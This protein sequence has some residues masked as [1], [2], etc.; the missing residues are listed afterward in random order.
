MR[1]HTWQLLGAVAAISTLVVLAGCDSAGAGGGSGNGGSSDDPPTLDPASEIPDTP[2]ELTDSGGSNQAANLLQ[3]SSASFS[4]FADFMDPPPEAQSVENANVS[5]QAIRSETRT[6]TSGGLTVTWTYEELEDRHQ[7]TV[8][9]DGSYDGRTYSNWTL[10]EGH[11]LKNAY[12]GEFVLFDETKPDSSTEAVTWHWC[13][14]SGDYYYVFGVTGDVHFQLATN[15]SGSAGEFDVY[16]VGSD[17]SCGTPKTSDETFILGWDSG[18]GVW[19]D[20]QDSS[21]NGSWGTS[22]GVEAPLTNSD[23]A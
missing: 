16:T 11:T 8:V 21:N 3:S 18:G 2:D 6:W 22:P 5:A 7:W 10:M 19:K 1:R 13:E 20:L 4:T 23:D 17:L 12:G 9:W 15:G 14:E